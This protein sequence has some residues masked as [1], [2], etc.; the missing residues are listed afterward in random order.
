MLQYLLQAQS[1]SL[2]F[3]QHGLMHKQSVVNPPVRLSL[4]FRQHGLMH[5]QS[6]KRDQSEQGK[7]KKFKLNLLCRWRGASTL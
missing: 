4:T 2:I 3:R 1:A 5:K 6:E 7:K